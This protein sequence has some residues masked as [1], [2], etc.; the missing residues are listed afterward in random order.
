MAKN[1]K[2]L[3]GLVNKPYATTPQV[4]A[5][6]LT[7]VTRTAMR[8]P[9]ATR[10]EIPFIVDR[11]E[12][13]FQQRLHDAVQVGFRGGEECSVSVVVSV[14]DKGLRGGNKP[15]INRVAQRSLQ[16]WPGLRMS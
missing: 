14:K 10:L 2:L 16:K 13:C 8:S 1:Q 15:K 5:T 12:P 11:F 4:I 7:E 3:V 9:H 6:L